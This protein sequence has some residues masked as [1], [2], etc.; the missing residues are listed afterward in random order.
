MLFCHEIFRFYII[1]ISLGSFY[2]LWPD[3][4][5]KQTDKIGSISPTCPRGFWKENSLCDAKTFSNVHRFWCFNYLLTCAN[6]SG[7]AKGTWRFHGKRILTYES[8]KISSFLNDFL[9]FLFYLFISSSMSWIKTYF[10]VYY[11]FISIF[12][13]IYPTSLPSGRIAPAW[14]IQDGE[15][16]AS[17]ELVVI[18]EENTIPYCRGSRELFTFCCCCCYFWFSMFLF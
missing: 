5:F 8:S 7:T 13:L 14:W 18:T 4:T 10:T 11:H 6:V 9:L 17:C 1:L 15:H 12:K 3:P 16:N 2:N